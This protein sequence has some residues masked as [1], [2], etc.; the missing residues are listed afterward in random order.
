MLRITSP[1]SEELEGLVHKTI[2]CCI[3]VHRALG[4]GLLES[5]YSRAVCIE[6]SEAGIP[7]EAEKHFPVMYRR[8]LLCHQRL[9][10]IVDAQI[11]LEIKS[12]EH[13]SSVH[14]AQ[15]LNYL[16]VSRLHVGLLLNFNVAVLQ[17]G[18]KRVVL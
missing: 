6:P 4:P 9:D 16:H 5:I 2:G 13:L 17:D 12:V 18:L 10:L 15:L 1:L 3:D 8:H 11:V 7:F 14:R